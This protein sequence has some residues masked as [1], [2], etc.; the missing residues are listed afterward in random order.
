MRGLVKEPLAN[1]TCA[2]AFTVNPQTFQWRQKELSLHPL[3]K[4]SRWGDLNKPYKTGMSWLAFVYIGSLLPWLQ[5]GFPFACVVCIWITVSW[6]DGTGDGCGWQL[7]KSYCNQATAWQH[8]MYSNCRWLWSKMLGYSH[9]EWSFCISDHSLRPL[10]AWGRGLA[11][12]RSQ[13]CTIP[14]LYARLCL[15]TRSRLQ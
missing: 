15:E 1:C 6:S 8:W 14:F 4:T 3:W 10:H 11:F 7:C 13:F 9:W 12:L 5:R 2:L